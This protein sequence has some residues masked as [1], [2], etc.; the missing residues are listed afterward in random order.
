MGVDGFSSGDKLVEKHGIP[1]CEAANKLEGTGLS[2]GSLTTYK[3]Q[4]RKI[5]SE[6]GT[7]PDAE[8]VIDFI[9]D[10]DVSGST[11][12][13]M[14][15]AIKKYYQALEEFTKAE[16]LSNLSK[17]RDLAKDFSAS[18]KVENW[19]TEQE[20]LTILDKI[21]PDKGEKQERIQLGSKMFIATAEHK[22]LVAT[23]YYTGLRISEALMLEVGDFYFEDNEVEVYRLKKGG[24]VVKRDRIHQTDKYLDIVKDYIEL[25]DIDSGRIFDFTS[26]TASNRIDD[27]EE[28]Y[29]Y[30]FGGFEQCD[31]LTP[32]KFR[33]GRVTAI[34]NTS[35]LE[36]ASRYVDHENLETTQ[37]YA[38][39]TTEDQRD[40]LP[41]A[42]E[43]ED[44]EVDKLLDELE[45]DSVD[46]L[47][48]AMSDS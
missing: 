1:A 30:M 35:G 13:T 22:A 21:C 34:A 9:A 5:V 23:L 16:R 24:D 28:V 44:S 46:E 12:N 7:N 27:V 2:Q 45:V 15:M 11:K 17:S 37:A 14:I 3:P 39:I 31:K 41:E 33:H 48:E 19:V 32:H 4:V 26:A 43:D 6:L 25:Y 18:M 10:A 20:V 8:G 47:K 36:A 40:M 42:Q 29:C 38:H